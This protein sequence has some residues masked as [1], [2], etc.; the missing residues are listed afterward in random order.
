MFHSLSRTLTGLTSWA[1]AAVLVYLWLT[2]VLLRF[3][4][5]QPWGQQL[6]AFLLSIFTTLGTGILHSIPGLFTIVVIFLL[7]RIFAR[8]V[9][10]IFRQIEKGDLTVPWL[11]AD[12]A[13]KAVYM[14]RTV[15]FGSFKSI[16]S[17]LLQFTHTTSRE[18]TACR[19]FV[20]LRRA[21]R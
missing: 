2:F 18:Q 7:T 17:L 11:H 10:G 15:A 19:A 4:Y 5:T 13:P 1:M 8:L 9:S 21:F 16:I 20:M 14:R 12:T 3:P 6:G